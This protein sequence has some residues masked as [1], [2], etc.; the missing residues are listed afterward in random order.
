MKKEDPTEESAAQAIIN[1]PK[2]VIGEASRKKVFDSISNCR[3]GLKTDGEITTLMGILNDVVENVLGNCID[4]VKKRQLDDFLRDVVRICYCRY[5]EREILN[6]ENKYIS[7]GDE[8]YETYVKADRYCQSEEG[9]SH[10][11][12][13]ILIKQTGEYLASPWM[14]LPVFTI[15][16]LTESLS[17]RIAPVAIAAKPPSGSK[18]L[19]LSLGLILSAYMITYSTEFRSG[20]LITLFTVITWLILSYWGLRYY[21]CDRISKEFNITHKELVSGS[22]DKE[23]LSG[24]LD[25]L[26]DKGLFIPSEVH[27]LFAMRSDLQTRGG[28]ASGNTPS[29]SPPNPSNKAEQSTPETT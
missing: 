15:F 1:T 9:N 17:A 7:R 28:S 3:K 14:H 27:T 4:T 16:L 20:W 23:E 26:V 25:K 12:K 2:P 6:Q 10:S 11:F 13:E 18:T 19:M 21:R 24:R 29:P 8:W 22:Y 5:H